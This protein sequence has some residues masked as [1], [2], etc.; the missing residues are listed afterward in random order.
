LSA[1]VGSHV[2]H[3]LPSVPQLGAEVGV[4]QAPLLSQHPVGH[5]AESQTQWPP[6]HCCPAAHA[7]LPPQLH[8]PIVHP[9]ATNA[10][11]EMH[12]LPIVPQLPSAGASQLAPAQ[13]PDAQLVLVHDVHVP[14]VQFCVE[15]QVE[16]CDPPVPQYWSVVPSSQLPW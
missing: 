14:V 16:H 9:S 7:E 3:A 13:Q 2:T 15:G 1:S 5:D 12:A 4:T 6:T 8:P 10:V 11:H